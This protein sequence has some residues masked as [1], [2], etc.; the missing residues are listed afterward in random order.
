MQTFYGGNV[1]CD[2]KIMYRNT[3]KVVY[4]PVSCKLARL[5]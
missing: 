4:D 5:V 1:F 2:R 3:I